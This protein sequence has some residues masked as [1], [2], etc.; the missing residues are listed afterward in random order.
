MKHLL[1]RIL[2]IL[3][4]FVSYNRLRHIIRVLVIKVDDG[5]MYSRV[6]RE[7]YQKY[8]QITIGYGTY[9]GCFNLDNIPPKVEFGN[10]CS[11]APNIKI[12]RANHPVYSFTSHPIMYNPIAGYVK[13]DLLIRSPLKIG[14]DV[15]IGENVIILPNV[16][17]IGNGSII[18]AGTI[19]TKDVAPYT[20]IGGNPS[21]IIRNRFKQEDIDYLESIKW[22]NLDKNKLCK[23]IP[24]L[25]ST[26][27]EHLDDR[28]LHYE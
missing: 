8:H 3:Y 19:V 14:H 5:E 27:K 9:G 22:W 1:L 28:L 7:L 4:S 18:G 17:F 12:Y 16:K 11:I 24:S 15:W 13:Q 6:I 26:L 2:F 10:Y 23:I 25:S 21:R 20:I